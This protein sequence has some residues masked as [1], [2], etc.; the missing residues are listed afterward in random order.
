MLAL[1]FAAAAVLNVLVSIARPLH[2]RSEHIAGYCF[3]FAT[4]W[5]MAARPWMFGVVRHQM[6]R[7]SDDLFDPAVDSRPALFW[8]SMAPA[9]ANGSRLLQD[10]NDS[11]SRLFLGPG[12]P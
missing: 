7:H 3:L 10:R 8:V 4:P 1:P 12:G 6:A 9:G 5:E 2:W 11:S